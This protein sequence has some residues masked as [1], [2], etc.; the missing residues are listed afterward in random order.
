M[1]I[2]ALLRD[3]F[4]GGQAVVQMQALPFR[5][6]AD[7]LARHRLDPNIPFWRNLKDGTDRFEVAKRPPS[8][9]VCGKRYVF[10]AKPKDP[11]ARLDP[12]LPCPVFEGD[13]NLTAAI[14][15]KHQ[16]DEASVKALVA[17]GAPAVKLVYQDGSQHPSFR[18]ALAAGTPAT[19]FFG[20]SSREY[21]NIS[22]PD[23][24]KAGP[25]IRN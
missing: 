23:A 6:T 18:A 2:Y 12:A 17:A 21:H 7:N 19:R 16:N 8:V 3:S 13:E 24:L 1:E 11:A 14:G 22:R 4:A 20:A 9:A 10:D 5:M 15:D 25:A